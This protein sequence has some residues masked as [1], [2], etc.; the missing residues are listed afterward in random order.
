MVCGVLND[1]VVAVELNEAGSGD[2]VAEVSGI[3]VGADAS[4]VD[5]QLRVLDDVADGRAGD[6]TIIDL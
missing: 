2:G 3:V 1:G 6:G 5:E 4:N